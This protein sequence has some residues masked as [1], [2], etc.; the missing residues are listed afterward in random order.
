MISASLENNQLLV[1]RNSAHNLQYYEDLV[2]FFDADLSNT[3]LK[4]RSFALYT[5]RQVLSDFLVRYELFKSVLDVP[6]SVVECGVLNGQGLLSFAQFSAILEPNNVNRLIFGLDTFTGFPAI[7]KEDRTGAPDRM[8]PGGMQVNGALDRIEQAAALYDQNRFIGHVPKVKLIQGNIVDQMDSFV[9]EHPY[10][11][12]SLLYLDV[13]LYQPTKVI[14]DKLLPRVPKGGIV[15]FDE[16]NMQDYPGET[17]AALQALDLSKVE[18]KRH[19]F[20]SRISY[21]VR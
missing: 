18:L 2:A 10:L 7:S 4:L 15:A 21:F 3:L 12:I 9:Q 16:L 13:D 14:L 1:G 11:L 17:Q 6:G 5:P 8:I 20:C 19:P